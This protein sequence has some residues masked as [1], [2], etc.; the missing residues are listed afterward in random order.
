LKSAESETKAGALNLIG[1]FCGLSQEFSCQLP[2]E[3]FLPQLR[4]NSGYITIAVWQL[5]FDL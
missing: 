3:G 5:V 1:S 2:I 4:L